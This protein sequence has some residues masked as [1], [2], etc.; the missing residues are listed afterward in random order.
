[1]QWTPSDRIEEVIKTIKKWN[2]TTYGDVYL[3]VSKKE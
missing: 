2:P 1:M 3:S